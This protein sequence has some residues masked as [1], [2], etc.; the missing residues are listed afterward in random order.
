M[1]WL[2]E[3]FAHQVLFAQQGAQV[4]CSAPV[5]TKTAEQHSDMRSGRRTHVPATRV[6]VRIES[7]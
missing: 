4:C 1:E 2:F 6:F 3:I 7:L 5:P